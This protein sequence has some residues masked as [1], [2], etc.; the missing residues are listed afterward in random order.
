MPSPRCLLLLLCLAVPPSAAAAE[1]PP[2]PAPPAPALT[3]LRASRMVDVVAGRMV[4]H[5]VVVIEGDRIRSV[6]TEAGEGIPAGAS[7]VDLGDLTLLPGLIDVHTHLSY[8]PEL[9]P[10]RFGK[11]AAGPAA[12]RALLAARNARMTLLAGFTTVREL[13]SCCFTDVTLMRAIDAG[14]VEGPRI[15]PS[16]Y[17][18]TITGG[19]CD[20]TSLEPR[21]FD[22]GPEQGTA[23]GDQEIREAVR[24][25]RKHGAQWI[26]TCADERKFDR[27]ELALMAEEAHRFGLRLAVH[28]WE[29]ESVLAALQ[30]GAD[31]I[32]H[33]TLLDDETLRLFKERGTWLVPTMYVT[34]TTQPEHFPQ[35]LRSRL[36]REMPLYRESLRRAVAAGVRMAFGSD[37]GEFPHGENAKEFTALAAY[38][39]PPLEL[40][41]MATVH[42]AALLGLDD[43]GAIAA[44][45][46]AD[47]VAVPGDPL[48]DPGV[49]QDVRFVMK[50]GAVAKKP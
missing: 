9:E 31:S 45:R 26:K 28:V 42:A 36:E 29:T 38:G 6:G 35:P 32:E 48:A 27:R 49:L 3:V 50:G 8:S 10:V 22:P 2:A 46:L 23:D 4:P 21:V 15:I 47:L 1:A 33:V 17:N 34:D 24:L 30:A 11:H 14:W 5:P 25:Q 39:I 12:G 20:Y 37:A 13:G 16:G 19:G 7:V 44:G 18:L 43:R 40:L 41:R